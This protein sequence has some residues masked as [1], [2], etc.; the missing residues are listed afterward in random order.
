M[1]IFYISLSLLLRYLLPRNGVERKI[2]RGALNTIQYK[3]TIKYFIVGGEGI[4]QMWRRCR[5]R[6]SR[7]DERWQK[8]SRYFS[9]RRREGGG[10]RP[11]GH[12]GITVSRTSIFILERSRPQ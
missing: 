7:C 8:R 2:K 3:L 5:Y 11:R 10:G 9:Y 6:P 1:Y 12:G 4:V